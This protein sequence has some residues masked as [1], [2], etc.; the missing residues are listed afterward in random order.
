MLIVSRSTRN[1][2]PN[3][4]IIGVEQILSPCLLIGKC[5]REI[6]RDWAVDTVLD[7]AE[8]FFVNPYFTLESFARSE[9]YNTMMPT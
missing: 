6:P 1:R 9:L 2:C 7:L 4:A 5:G 3:A 8:D